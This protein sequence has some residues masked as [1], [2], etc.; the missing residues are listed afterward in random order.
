MIDL[1]SLPQFCFIRTAIGLGISGAIL[2]KRK[3]VDGFFILFL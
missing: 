2:N 3:L 1:I